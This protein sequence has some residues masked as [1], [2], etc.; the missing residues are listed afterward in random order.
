MFAI[1]FLLRLLPFRRPFVFCSDV[2]RSTGKSLPVGLGKL[3]SS[4]SMGLG[5]L[6]SLAKLVAFVRVVDLVMTPLVL[7]VRVR[8]VA[9]FP[10]FLFITVCAALLPVVSL[11]SH[12]VWVTNGTTTPVAGSCCDT[13]ELSDT[14]SSTSGVAQSSD[15][16]GVLGRL[17]WFEGHRWPQVGQC[18]DPTPSLPYSFSTSGEKNKKN[19]INKTA[20]AGCFAQHKKLN[21]CRFKWHIRLQL[22]SMGS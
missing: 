14:T 17:G 4:S 16:W 22:V 7:R 12:S 15:G 5:K 2:T 9:V 8:M 3:V 18:G 20:F 10:Y 19:G 6:T 21:L 11:R 1:T 13:S